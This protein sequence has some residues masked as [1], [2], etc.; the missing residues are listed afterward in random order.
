ECGVLINAAGA[1]S[2]AIARDLG[3]PV[4]MFAAGPPLI[5]LTS[6]NAWAGPSLAAVDGT[7]LLR[8]GSDGD[9]VTGSFPRLAADLA[10]GTAPVPPDRV[11]RGIARL[12]EVVPGLGAVVPTLVWSGVEGYLPDLR[13]VI[14]WS[15]TTPGLMHAFGFSGH[16]FQLAPG[17]GAAV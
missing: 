11:E 2:A 8:P 14:G 5:A 7:V 6:T 1:W 12:L 10:G 3:E 16:G 15:A 9:A 17:A 4:P 13:P